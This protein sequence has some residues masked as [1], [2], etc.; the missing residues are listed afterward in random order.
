MKRRSVSTQPVVEPIVSELV[1]ERSITFVIPASKGSGGLKIKATETGAGEIL[2][3]M[4]VLEGAKP[5]AD[6][7]AL[8]FDMSTSLDLGSI[9]ASGEKVT[10]IAHG[11]VKDVGRGQ[12]VQGQPLSHD[13]GVGLSPLGKDGLA[14]QETSFTL[15]TSLGN[16]SLDDIGGMNFAARINGIGSKPVITTVAPHAPDAVQ[17][18]EDILEDGVPDL[19]CATHEPSGIVFHPL[20]NDTDGDG[21][22]LTIIATRGAQHGKVEIID[23]DD[24][25]DLVGDAVRY[26]PFADFSGSDTFEYLISDGAGGTDF[27]SVDVTVHAV[28]DVP[29]VMIE[30]LAT[31][32]A[33]QMILRVTSAQ[34]DLDLSEY[35]DRFELSATYTDG[36]VV[37]NFAD[38]ISETGYNPDTQ[39]TGLSYDFLIDLPDASSMLFDLHV[40]SVSK[41]LSNGDEETGI[42]TV[43]IETVAKNVSFAQTFQANDKNIWSSG[44]ADGG[45][46]SLSLPLHLKVPDQSIGANFYKDATDTSF[47]IRTDTRIDL[48]AKDMTINTN[49]E[50]SFSVRGGQVDANLAYEGAINTLYNKTVDQLQFAT[51]AE[52]NLAQ[53]YFT[54]TTPSLGFDLKLKALDYNIT[55]D[56][57]VFGYVTFDAVDTSLGTVHWDIPIPDIPTGL[58]LAHLLGSDGLSMV[59][60]SDG[61]ARLIENPFSP[62]NFLITLPELRKDVFDPVYNNDLATFELDIPS[63]AVAKEW[64]NETTNVIGGAKSGDLGSVTLDL[65]GIAATIVGIPNPISPKLF[66]YSKSIF[67]ATASAQAF[68]YDLV[69]GIQYFQD[70]SLAAQDLHGS[71]LFEDGSTDEFIFG[72]SFVVDNASSKDVNGDGEIGYEVIMDPAASFNTHAGVHISVRDELDLVKFEGSITAIGRISKSAVDNLD[73]HA[74]N[75][76]FPI[77][78]ADQTFALDF[79]A[80]QYTDFIG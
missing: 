35:I 21:D 79:D 5:R 73:L 7:Q 19:E 6:L 64:Q 34:T 54:T 51:S 58:N 25:D 15:T 31:S 48:T 42:E 60:V 33:D 40:R 67:T 13:I 49:V 66:H 29:S 4:I 28:A 17:E 41:E 20:E 1:F 18:A 65:D 71:I 55:L 12:N 69:T 59:R 46:A 2:F 23:G 72:E 32:R 77:S 70:H 56:P 37:A 53:S 80:S 36:S 50:L 47:G 26:T 57:S 68:D 61:Y 45:D 39:E 27:A 11:S 38:M 22:I 30:A 62:G 78:V 10:E 52:A 74:V 8:F 3:E 9:G 14:T 44:G 75:N 63:F 76:G 24:A 16:L 43:R